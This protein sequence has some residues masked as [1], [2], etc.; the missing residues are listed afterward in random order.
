[1]KYSVDKIENNI[2]ILEDIKT[3]YIKE[4][5]IEVFNFEIREKDILVYDGFVYKKDEDEKINRINM[6]REKMNRL[7]KKY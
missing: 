4:E 1:M 5:N 6:I 2:V 3:G 7:K